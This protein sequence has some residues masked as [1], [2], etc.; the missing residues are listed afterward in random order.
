MTNHPLKG[1]GQSH[2]THCKFCWLQTCLEQLKPESSNFVCRYNISSSVKWQVTNQL[3]DHAP[4]GHD[5]GN[6]AHFYPR[7]AMLARVLAI[8]VCLCV[9][10][11]VSVCLSVTCR[12]SIKTAK[13]RIM[14]AT[15][16]DSPGTLVFWQQQS[17]VGDPHSLWNLRSKWSTPLSTLRFRPIS[18]H[19]ASTVRA[20]EKSLISTNR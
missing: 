16:C 12:Y 5:Q 13:R 9:C 14:Q 15:P 6:V 1:R 19:S 2:V 20:G 7:D 4:N 11:C 3:P 17:L 18:A 8:I 10:A